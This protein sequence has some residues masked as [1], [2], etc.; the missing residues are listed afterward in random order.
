[1]KFEWTKVKALEE[2]GLPAW[3]MWVGDHCLGWLVTSDCAGNWVVFHC[4]T[5]EPDKA[6]AHPCTGLEHGKTIAE[7]WARQSTQ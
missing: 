1:M 5:A 3:E 6:W 7:Q 4:K 2:S